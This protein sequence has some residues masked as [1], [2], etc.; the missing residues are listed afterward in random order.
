MTY[1][2]RVR[3]KPRMPMMFGRGS[4]VAS[5]QLQMIRASPARMRSR[6]RRR[7]PKGPMIVKFWVL[8]ALIP[9]VLPI[10]AV[11]PKIERDMGGK[12]SE[13]IPS[14]FNLP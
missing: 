14:K 13:A 9:N 12:R 2:R 11:V 4:S 8:I 3:S 6:E 1:R 5:H 10:R 7:K